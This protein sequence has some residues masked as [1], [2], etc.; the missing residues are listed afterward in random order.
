MSH[1]REE[2][3]K[4]EFRN[5][6]WPHFFFSLAAAQLEAKNFTCTAQW[7]REA[8]KKTNTK[9]KKVEEET[10]DFMDPALR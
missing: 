8:E 5:S 7:R 6:D 9:K 4:L 10:E 1:E 2:K 3:V